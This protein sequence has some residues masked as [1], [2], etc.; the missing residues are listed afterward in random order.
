MEFKAKIYSAYRSSFKGESHP[1]VLN[2]GAGKL[3]PI[4]EP[5]IHDLDQSHLAVDLGCGAG[6]LLLALRDLGFSNLA[7]CDLSAEQVAIAQSNFPGVEEKNLFAFLEGFDDASIGL[8]TIF[9][10]IEHLGPQPTFDLMPLIFQKLVLGGRLIAH[11]P[12]GLSPMV[13]H[14]FWGDMTHEWC[15]TPQSA[16]TL[17][18]LHG[19]ENFAAAEHLGASDNI[20][21]RVRAAA[22]EL[23]RRGY[24]LANAIETGSSGGNIWTRNFAFKA[25]KPRKV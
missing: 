5:W 1:K 15:L 12:N 3:K 4:L 14:V 7:G 17:C 20:K 19:F 13:G 6:E 18:S 9:D 16:A 11:L 2:F 24:Q 8:I 10:V 23:L 22:W 25:D 21:G